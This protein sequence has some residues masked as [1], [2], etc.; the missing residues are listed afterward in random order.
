MKS[1][2]FRVLLSLVLGIS[3][4]QLSVSSAYARIGESQRE[5]EDRLTAS[6]GII[7][8]DDVIEE[9]RRK[10]MPYMDYMEFLGSSADVRIYFKTADGRRPK[11]SELEEKRINSGWDL[12]VVYV[13]G[14]SVIEIYRRSQAMTEFEMNHL[15]VM[16]AG[17]S[18]WKKVKKG[19]ELETVFEIEMLSHDESIRAKKIGSDRILFVDSKVDIGLAQK[20]ASDLFKKAPISVNGF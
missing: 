1:P 13:N 6:G 17:D 9:N 3:A 8:R 11:S 19:S 2:K 7:Y 18:G 4:L 16:Q 5:L 10:G 15:I 12:H 14:K 20:R